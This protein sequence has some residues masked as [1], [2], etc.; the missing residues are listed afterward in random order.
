MAWYQLKPEC[1]VSLVTD[2]DTFPDEVWVYPTNGYVVPKELLRP[3]YINGKVYGLIPSKK[4]ELQKCTQKEAWESAY[5]IFG[6]RNNYDIYNGCYRED[7]CNGQGNPVVIKSISEM[8][9]PREI[10]IKYW[11]DNEMPIINPEGRK[12]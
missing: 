7:L 11:T 6:F 3:L 12:I 4:L 5:K 2:F 9:I 10:L 8:Q 1:I